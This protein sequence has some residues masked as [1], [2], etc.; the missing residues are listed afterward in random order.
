MSGKIRKNLD[1]IL[2]TLFTYDEECEEV[3]QYLTGEDLVKKTELSSKEI[4]DAINVLHELGFVEWF[5]S[6]VVMPFEFSH[7]R[8]NSRG[9]Y[10]YERRE[11]IKN[12]IEDFSAPSEFRSRINVEGINSLSNLIDRLQEV[13]PSPVG[14]PYGFTDY[15]WEILSKRKADTER[16]YVVL[17]LKFDS[18]YYDT[19]K[20]LENIREYFQITLKEYNKNHK[21]NVKLEFQQLRAGYG[22][23]LFNQIARDIISSDIAVFDTSDLNPNV[24][25]EIGV[26]LT[27][28][29]RVFL[30]KCKGSQKP[31]SDISGQTY[32]EYNDS[33]IEFTDSDFLV[34]MYSM[35]ERALRKKG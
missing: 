17:G 2:K 10:E 21:T 8:I 7:V 22:E 11:S 35:V 27:W 12:A 29:S 25:L 33:A 16:L 30:I 20:L 23:H 19:Y 3:H 4:N 32:A 18:D 15:D 9:K 24:F 14:S 13:P 1:L 5:K 28:G 34:N 26:A 6:M 31:S